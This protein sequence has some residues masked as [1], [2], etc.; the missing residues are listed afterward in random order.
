MLTNDPLPNVV[1][2]VHP[3][4]V[5]WNDVFTAVKGALGNRLPLVPYADW[6]EKLEARA[7]DATARDLNE[8]VSVL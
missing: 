4:P 3:H 6:L 1:N 5:S 8:V 2:V 7:T